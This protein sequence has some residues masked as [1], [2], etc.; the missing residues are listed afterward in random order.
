MIWRWMRSLWRWDREYLDAA[1]HAGARVL[2]RQR[3]QRA[4][5]LGLETA[6]A[7]PLRRQVVDDGGR[8]GLVDATILTAGAADH[9]IGIERDIRVR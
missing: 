7:D 9:T 5:A 2:R 3:L 8:A 6:P 4:E 1:V